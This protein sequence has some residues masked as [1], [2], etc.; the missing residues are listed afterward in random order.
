MENK[1]KY[2]C[3]QATKYLWFAQEHIPLAR[4]LRIIHNAAYSYRESNN[5]CNNNR[6][7]HTHWM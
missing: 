4:R 6:R 5:S 2:M 7:S 3:N 1:T